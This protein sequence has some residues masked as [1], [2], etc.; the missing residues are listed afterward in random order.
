[1]AMEKE[2]IVGLLYLTALQI[3]ARQIDRVDNDKHHG[4]SPSSVM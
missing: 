4:G 3:N 2:S 1:M